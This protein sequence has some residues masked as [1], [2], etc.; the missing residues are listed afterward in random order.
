MIRVI[1][2]IAGLLIALVAWM[3]AYNL[4]RLMTCKEPDYHSHK[5]FSCHCPGWID[6]MPP[7]DGIEVWIAFTCEI[8]DNLVISFIFIPIRIMS[9]WFILF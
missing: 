5:T 1:I 6:W 7:C 3:S 8:V 2:K 9:V 4:L